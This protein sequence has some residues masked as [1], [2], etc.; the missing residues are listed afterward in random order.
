MEDTTT[1]KTFCRL[2]EPSCGLVAEVQGPVLISLKPDRDH[3]VTEGY[4]CHKGLA[5]ADLHAD[6]D[7]V[8]HPMQ[9]GADGT[10]SQVS[11]D[12]A[13]AGIATK[14]K[15]ITDKYGPESVAMYT[16]NPLAFN[17]L[18]QPATGALARGLGIRRAFSSGTQDCANKFAASEAIYGSS[19]I[20]P[21]PDVAKT[22]FC[23]VIGSNPRVSHG[24]FISIANFTKEMKQATTRGAR[25]VFINP[26]KVET[27][28]KG[29]GD[30]VQIKPDTDV[31]FLAS[32]LH[33]LERTGGFDESTLKNHGA[34]VDGLRAFI[35][36]YDPDTTASVT[37]IPAA[38]VRELAAAWRGA[39]K[40]SVY[41]STGIN[42]GRQGT[43]A[44]WLVQM[45]AFATGRLDAEGGNLKSDGF[46]PN[47]K[48]GAAPAG[49]MYAETEFGELRRGAMPGTLM[50]DAILDSE[51]PVR[52]MFVVAGNPLISIAGGDRLLKALE[53]LELLVCID[54]YRNTTGELA[55]YVLPSTDMLERDDLNVC[56]IGMSAKPFAQYTPAVVEPTGER[57]TEHWIC[58]R[59]LQELGQPSDL[60]DA[61]NDPW[62]KWRYML[63]RGS[64]IDLAD[65]MADPQVVPLPIPE[66]GPFFE[67]QIQTEDRKVDCC[68][69]TFAAAL[70]NAR[71]IFDEMASEPDGLKMIHRRD[72]WMMNSWFRNL[73]RMQKGGRTTN[74][75]WMNP[76]DAESRGMK[77]GDT[78]RVFNRNGSIDAVV[79]YDDALMP[80]VVAMSHGWGQKNNPGMP[81]AQASPG[82]NQNVLLPSGPGSFERLSSQAHMTGIP[83]EVEALA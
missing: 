14:L 35:A 19:T 82:V 58:H 62:G 53:Q 29:V 59:I 34:N 72:S 28:D 42:M 36:E 65:L 64:D 71:A 56:G 13:M 77:H 21:I 81:V 11:W 51:T 44:Y 33:E 10:W 52:A 6:P 79:D 70:V 12:E 50:A 5:V 24:S 47:A 26:R 39:D 60:D 54:L 74:P 16:G 9:R 3:P 41:A 2:C 76:V 66:A 63:K 7:R 25:F 23:L 75:L 80:G 43:I 32:L 67:E 49:L 4:A 1:V 37:G 61:N 40:P 45:L 68:P 8:N 73:P 20:H 38:T 78:V 15:A 27:P 31:Y 69:P 83:V 46:Y 55:H 17:A 57:R 18:G 30:T 22:D 48:A